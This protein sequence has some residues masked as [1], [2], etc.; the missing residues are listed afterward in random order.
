MY[1][2]SIT[3]SFHFFNYAGKQ[4][5]EKTMIKK[6]TTTSGEIRYLFQTYLGVDPLTG[7]ERRT[8]RR[9]FRTQ[10]EAKQAERNL[11][12]DIEENG[13]PSAGASQIPNPTFEEERS[14][15]WEN[16]KPRSSLP[17]LKMSGPRLKKWLR[18][19]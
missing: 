10:K 6:Y 15:G 17:H 7:K 8:T 4:R 11:L 5:K 3:N 1:K 9:G 19:F 14:C 16:Y 13:L 18:T 12:L 2:G